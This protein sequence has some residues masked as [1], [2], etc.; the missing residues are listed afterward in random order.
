MDFQTKPF[1]LVTVV[2][3]NWVKIDDDKGNVNYPIDVTKPIVVSGNGHNSGP[4]IN[5]LLVDVDLYMWGGFLGCSWHKFPTF[6][7]L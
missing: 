1:V 5:K 7:L 2:K 4:Q 3:G 6:G